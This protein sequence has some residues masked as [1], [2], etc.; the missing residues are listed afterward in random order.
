MIIICIKTLFNGTKVHWVLYYLEVVRN[1]HLLGV[2][3]LVKDPCV[4]ELP[5]ARNHSFGCL[6]PRFIYGRVIRKLRLLQLVQGRR[7]QPELSYFRILLLKQ[8]HLL[9][10]QRFPLT[11]L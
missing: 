6:V 5:Q 11:V 10:S 2:H 7:V 4:V 1:T 8:V 9:V 3:R